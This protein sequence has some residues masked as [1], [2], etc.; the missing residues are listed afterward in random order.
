[1]NNWKKIDTDIFWGEIAPTD[2][3][4]QIYENDEVFL[5]ALAGFV[6]GGINA[7]D[8]VIV[9]ATDA[10]LQALNNRLSSYGVHVPTLVSD[11]RYVPLNAEAT[12]SRFMVNGWPDETLFA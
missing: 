6:G 12:L 5:D 1:M 7:G 4:L 8:C 10:H 9:I 3:V 11:E 2:H